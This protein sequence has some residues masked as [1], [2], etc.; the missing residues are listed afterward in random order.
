MKKMVINDSVRIEGFRIRTVNA[1]DLTEIKGLT[2]EGSWHI[3][4]AN[5]R[6]SNVLVID[7]TAKWQL[8]QL[9]A[10]KQ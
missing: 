10:L 7:V 1:K 4:E 5:L 2:S 6:A 3:G 9:N 8:Q